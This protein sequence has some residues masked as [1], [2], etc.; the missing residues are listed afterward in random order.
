MPEKLYNTY[1]GDAIFGSLKD[2]HCKEIK[3][4]RRLPRNA[5]KLNQIFNFFLN[6]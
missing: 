1:F 6:T 2:S 4:E 5:D 3:K